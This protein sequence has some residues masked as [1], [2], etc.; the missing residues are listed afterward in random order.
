M[1]CPR[2]YAIKQ[3]AVRYDAQVTINFADDSEGTGSDRAR[4][5]YERAINEPPVSRSAEI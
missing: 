5:V 1:F 2:H 3:G 4:Q